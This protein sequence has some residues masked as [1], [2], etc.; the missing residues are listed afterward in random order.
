MA[1]TN[2]AKWRRDGGAIILTGHETTALPRSRRALRSLRRIDRGRHRPAASHLP[3]SPAR[4]RP[5]GTLG[6]ELHGAA[7]GL[8]RRPSQFLSPAR[9]LAGQ[10]PKEV[11]TP[12][13]AQPGADVH[14][15]GGVSGLGLAVLAPARTFPGSS[16]EPQKTS[17]PNE[18]RRTAMNNTDRRRFNAM[19]AGL[20]PAGVD[21]ARGRA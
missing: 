5:Q 4:E 17:R 7:S 14:P 19:L 16:K 12:L 21:P 13:A 20:G 11:G 10:S 1:E 6:G 15:S 8:P 18:G 3:P 2:C 9:F